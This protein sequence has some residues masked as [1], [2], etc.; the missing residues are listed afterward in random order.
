VE[1]IVMLCPA[2]GSDDVGLDAYAEWDVEKQEW[3][4]GATYDQHQCHDCGLSTK[5]GFLEVP[6]E[7]YALYMEYCDAMPNGAELLDYVEWCE[8]PAGWTHV[9]TSV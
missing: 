9:E 6:T 5:H 7:N 4:L 8:T 3:V 2:C 1:K